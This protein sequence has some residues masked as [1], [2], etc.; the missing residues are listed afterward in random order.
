MSVSV[1]PSALP[2]FDPAPAPIDSMSAS[3][4]VPQNPQEWR[5]CKALCAAVLDGKVEHEGYRWGAEE[6]PGASLSTEENVANF[7]EATARRLKQQDEIADALHRKASWLLLHGQKP[8]A[9]V[10]QEFDRFLELVKS[11]RI[12][13]MACCHARSS[14][15][16]QG[17]GRGNE[18]N[19]VT[20]YFASQEHHCSPSEVFELM[21][22]LIVM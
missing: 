12:M 9:D 2:T 16:D 17:K 8:G 13:F 11:T 1:Q 20:R 19:P 6:R 7:S 10:L 5:M 4:T 14:I 21:E 18:V 3:G 15:G 22:R